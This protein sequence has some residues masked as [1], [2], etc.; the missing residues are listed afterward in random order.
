MLKTEFSR[1]RRCELI[2]ERDI[3]ILDFLFKQDHGKLTD[4]DWNE[5]DKIQKDNP[6]WDAYKK[7]AKLDAGN[8][9]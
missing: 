5:M 4:E 7:V 1:C 3:K 2:S 6:N 8:E 9:A